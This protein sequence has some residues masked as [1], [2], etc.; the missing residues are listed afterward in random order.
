VCGLKG[1]GQLAEQPG[2]HLF[3][4]CSQGR[5]QGTFAVLL[6]AAM[7]VECGVPGF[8]ELDMHSAAVSLIG[9]PSDQA[10]LLDRA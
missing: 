3:L 7:L 5:E 6:G 4:V 9:G 1:E 8:G 10:G 2:E